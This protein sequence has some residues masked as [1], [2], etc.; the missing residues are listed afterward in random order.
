MKYTDF[1]NKK[2]YLHDND[3]VSI[4]LEQDSTKYELHLVEVFNKYIQKDFIIIEGGSHLGLHTIRLSDLA[5]K[6]FIY[7]FEAS[8]R[9]YDKLSDTLKYNNI[10]NVELYNKALYKEKSEVFLEEHIYADQDKLNFNNKNGNK[11]D[12]IC[13]DDF[14]FDKVDFIKLDIEGSEYFAIEGCKNTIEKCKPIIVYEY[15]PNTPEDMN[16]KILLESLGYNIIQLETNGNKH[17]D[18][19]AIHKSKINYD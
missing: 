4:W 2:I 9:N 13:I 5:N 17:W 10:T 16:P 1:L 12:A 15:L 8:K 7:S 11:V 18:Y 19:L 6:G 3:Q 14:N